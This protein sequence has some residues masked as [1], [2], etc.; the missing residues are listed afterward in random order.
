[1]KKYTVIAWRAEGFEEYEV[2][3]TICSATSPEM[4]QTGTEIDLDRGDTYYDYTTVKEYEEG[5][6]FTSGPSF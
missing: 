4:A 5:D 1:M 6:E 3:R 2:N